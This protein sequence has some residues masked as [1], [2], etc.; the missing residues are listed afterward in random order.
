MQFRPARWNTDTD[1]QSNINE[2]REALETLRQAGVSTSDPDY[3]SIARSVEAF[4]DEQVD[5][6]MRRSR[7]GS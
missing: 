3:T 2:G 1:I 7:H 6:N 5:R 4:E